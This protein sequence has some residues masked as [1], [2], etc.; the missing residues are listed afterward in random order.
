MKKKNIHNYVLFFYQIICY[1]LTHIRIEFIFDI[2]LVIGFRD[3][4]QLLLHFK[5]KELQE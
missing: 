2:L 4:L 3:D 1:I 5:C